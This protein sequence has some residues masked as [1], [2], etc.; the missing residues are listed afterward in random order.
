M[1]NIVCITSQC[2]FVRNAYLKSSDTFKLSPEDIQEVLSYKNISEKFTYCDWYG[3]ET[4][5]KVTLTHV[6]LHKYGNLAFHIQCSHSIPEHY[7]PSPLQIM[8]GKG[9]LCPT[10]YCVRNI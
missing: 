7:F 10:G 8:K 4:E 5:V 2:D 3:S 9:L 1:T 6:T